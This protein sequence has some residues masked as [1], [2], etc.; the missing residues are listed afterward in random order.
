MNLKNISVR[1]LFWDKFIVLYNLQHIDF[2]FI[3]KYKPKKERFETFFI[4][5]F[6]HNWLG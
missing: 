1:D 4:A 5:L 2:L 6:K 3:H